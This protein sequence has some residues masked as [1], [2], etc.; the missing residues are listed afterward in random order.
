MKVNLPRQFRASVLFQEIHA[1]FGRFDEIPPIVDFDFSYMSFVRPS[2]VVF[3]SNLCRYLQRQGSRV[4]FSGLSPVSPSIRFLDDALFFEQHLGHKLISESV[5]RVTTQPLLEIH[6]EQSHGWI[7]FRLI[8]W[9]SNCSGVE[10]IHLAEFRT[11]IS[12]LFNNIKDHTELDV[13]SIFAQW[14]PNERSLEI[15][16]ADFGAGIPKTVERVCEGLSDSEAISRAFEDGFTSQSLPTNR[17]V[18][19]HYLQQNV[20]E[21]LNG[22]IEVNSASGSLFIEKVGNLVR[23]MPYQHLGFCPGTLINMRISTDRIDRT[24]DDGAFTW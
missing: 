21:S 13:G 10:E 19:L 9:L 17:G 7:G 20:V 24:D 18:G 2:G 3:L 11:C 6:L 8:P 15:C 22:T 14:Y 1:R 12:E 23:K 4:T 5:P 16:L